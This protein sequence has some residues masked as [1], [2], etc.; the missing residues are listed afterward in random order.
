MILLIMIRSKE[1]FENNSLYKPYYK[2]FGLYVVISITMISL[3]FSALL[4]LVNSES[5]L[6]VL[7]DINHQIKR[8]T[9]ELS[10]IKKTNINLEDRILY[11]SREEDK[12]LL[13]QVIRAYLGYQ[14]TSEVTIVYQKN[15]S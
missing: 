2:R 10:T 12:D 1:I 5:G 6:L 7:K 14:S 9:Y 13:D 3:N 11:F 15:S 8:N 4:H